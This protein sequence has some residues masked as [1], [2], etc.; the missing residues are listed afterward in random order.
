MGQQRI[1]SVL[2]RDVTERKRQEAHARLLTRELEHRVYDILARIQTVVERSAD[3]GI[4][5]RE[6]R[7]AFYWIA[8]SP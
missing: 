7:E 3:E 5:L 6:F 4:S 8:S 2:L 1:Y